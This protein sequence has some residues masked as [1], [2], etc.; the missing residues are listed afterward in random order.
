MI[1]SLAPER[2]RRESSAKTA[3]ALL[4]ALGALMIEKQTTNIPIQE[5]AQRSGINHGLVKYHFGNKAAME[6]AL[7]RRAMGPAMEQL[8]HLDESALSPKDKLRVHVSGMVNTYFR[9]PYVNRLMHRMMSE[10]PD[11]YG[12]IIIEEFSKPTAF[13][14]R[15]ILEEGVA[16]GLFRPV[17]PI[18]FY[19][20]VVG[21]CDQLF[22]GR[23]QLKHVFGMAAIDDDL[24]RRYIDHL[25]GVVTIGIAALEMPFAG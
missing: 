17:D 18:S 25:C 22:H 16:Q 5:L 1:S 23:Y 4:D 19:F 11:L 14:Q 24:R 3:G 6:L 8:N 20:H 7:L 15:K 12:P 13:A 9:Y 10:N 2:T 21:A